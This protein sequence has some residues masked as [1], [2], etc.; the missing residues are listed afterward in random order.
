MG[1]RRL[2]G[3]GLAS[4]AAATADG[5]VVERWRAKIVTVEGSGCLWWTGAIS[6]RGHGRFWYASGRV[7]IAHRFAFAV[8]HDVTALARAELLGH[9]CDNPLC[10]RVHPEHVVRSTYVANRREWAILKK[11]TGSPLGDPRG[12]RRRARELRDLAREDP[13]LLAADQAALLAL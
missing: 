7:V 2:D 10:Q 1:A 5:D 4:L 9:R 12:S 8:A 13:A 3:E 6:G 11:L